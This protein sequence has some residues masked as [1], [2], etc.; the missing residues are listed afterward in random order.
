MAGEAKKYTVTNPVRKDGKTYDRGAT[1]MLTEEE[2]AS[3][4]W[5]VE[6]VEAKAAGQQ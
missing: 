1:I 2:A 4:P 6:L 5:A 3:M